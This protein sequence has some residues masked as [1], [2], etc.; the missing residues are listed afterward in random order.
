MALP[1]TQTALSSASDIGSPHDCVQKS[2]PSSWL[3]GKQVIG[4][5]LRVGAAARIARGG[6]AGEDARL[7]GGLV[8]GAAGHE[9]RAPSEP[10]ASASIAARAVT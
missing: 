4:W 2:V 5:P 3:A 10:P 6:V 8:D 1:C 9:R 7:E